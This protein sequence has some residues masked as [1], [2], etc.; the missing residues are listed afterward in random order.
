M[1]KKS[2]IKRM[3]K[4][5]VNERIKEYRVLDSEIACLLA[6]GINDNINEG[7]QP[8]GGLIFASG[9]FYQPMVKY[10]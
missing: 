5:T 1:S 7:W 3:K 4:I 6:I 2:E 10:K 9:W 8:Y